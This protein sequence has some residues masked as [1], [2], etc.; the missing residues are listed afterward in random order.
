M[1]ATRHP[2]GQP[3]DTSSATVPP[4]PFDKRWHV[5]VDGK[6]YGPYT[7]HEIRQ[8]SEQHNI[9]GSDFVYAEDGSAWLQITNDPI[10]S[11]LFK[12][13]EPARSLLASRGVPSRHF[14][15]WLL[16]IAVVVAAGWIV[17]PYYAVYDLA[18]AVRE[19]DV[20]TLEARVAWDSVRQG[21]RG[22]LNAL[23]LQKFS[24]DAKADTSSGG[25]LGTDLA[26]MLG[27]VIV[28]RMV[29][30]YV[31]PQAVAA[32]N[33]A[34]KSDNTSSNVTNAAARNFNETIQSARNIRW[35][36]IKHAFFSRG[37]LT[38][39]VE[40]IP[41]HDPPLQH[42]TEFRFQWDGNWRL[43]RIILPADAM[44]GLSAAAKSQDGGGPSFASKLLAPQATTKP[45]SPIPERLP[46]PLEVTLV[47]KGFKASNARAGDYED[48]ITLQLSIKNILDKDIRAFDG[49]VTF[50]DLLDNEILS[51]KI[52]INEPLKADSI[53]SWHGAIKYN[54]FIDRHQRL[55]N[56]RQENLKIKFVTRKILFADGSSKEY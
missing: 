36:Q 39:R 33:R 37:P 43:I 10:L 16:G 30:S 27:P 48:N 8:M 52:V 4:H 6:T 56:E 51:S 5:H 7:G 21:L 17:W 26:V 13:S 3:S 15:K 41:D 53:L 20:S 47:S 44:H 19:G 49:V 46:Q 29:D 31:T 34:S 11:A 25:A 38:F 12:T 45:A 40:F 22:D 35:D 2:P 24:S 9:L 55:R 28:D 32:A 42:P 14:R 23:L 18:I 54:Q 1:A 50:N